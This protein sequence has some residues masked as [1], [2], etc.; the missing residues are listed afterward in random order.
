MQTIYPKDFTHNK[1]EKKFFVSGKAVHFDTTYLVKNPKT[2][3]QMEFKFSHSTG[4]EW[5]PATIWI[6][7]GDLGYELHLS[8]DDVTQRHQD[9]YLQTK[10]H[11]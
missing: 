2:D 8:N 9:A 5:D 4:S 6:F 10:L 11:N 3:G 7:E 1:V